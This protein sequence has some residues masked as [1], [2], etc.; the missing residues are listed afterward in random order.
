MDRAPTPL[1]PP[2]S[3]SGIWQAV[4]L[5]VKEQVSG[6]IF[7]TYL[8]ETA[9]ARMEEGVFTVTAPSDFVVEQLANRL[10]PSLAHTLNRVA[11]APLELSFEVAGSRT[12]VGRGASAP[13]RGVEPIL[14]P[15]APDPAPSRE[16]PPVAPSPAPVRA[17]PPVPASGLRLN[18]KYTF[19]T[20]V[21]GPS[22]QF[23]HAA[24]QGAAAEPGRKYNPLFLH[25]GVGL[26]K[27]H[28][29]Q[30]I[31]HDAV[32]KGLHI[33][34]VSSE[35]FTNEFVNAIR[36]RR[37]DDFRARYRGADVLLIDDIQFIAGK[38]GT[39]EEFFHTFND[40]HQHGRQIVITSD[41]SPKLISLL[42]DRLRSRFEWGLI[43]DV[44]PPDYETRLAILRSRADEQGMRV[45]EPV[46]ELI[47]QRVQENVRE[48]EGSLNRVVAFARLSGE[49]VTLA[50]ASRAIAD[51]TPAPSRRRAPAPEVIIDAVAD[52]FDLSPRMLAGKARDKHLV[53][54]RHI[55]MYLLRADA[56]RPLAEIGKLLG[57]RDHTTVMHGTEKIEGSLHIEPEL[58]REIAEI[59]AAIERGPVGADMRA[60][61]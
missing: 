56:G 53:H 3:P 28:L 21:V 13:A 43:V 49:D 48:L 46:L 34:Y 17:A 58:R 18:D 16:E 25:G 41:R 2:S 54:A 20:F 9:G 27:T 23:A 47:A 30:A 39:Q 40:L 1:P 22:N 57:K 19:D 52:Y 5:Q 10:R 37:A 26:G 50:I 6:P 11:G 45:P 38:E 61:G 32:N 55:A 4:L 33:V 42:E 24:A 14:F 36:E 59:R 31:G 35:Q 51:L 44:Q 60:I 15:P 7:A 12:A 29:L 8:Q